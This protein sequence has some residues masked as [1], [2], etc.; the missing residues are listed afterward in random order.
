MKRNLAFSAIFTAGM[1]LIGILISASL[2]TST[3]ISSVEAAPGN[4]TQGTLQILDKQGQPDSECPLKQTD[5]K[6]EIT[7]HLARVNV[8]Q[9]F[10][11]LQTEKI[12]AV[13]VFPL[14]HN[15][16]V[17][18]MSMTVGDRIIKGKIKPRAEDRKSTRLNSSHLGISYAVF[19]LKKK[20]T[21]TNNTITH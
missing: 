16:A 12:E 14:P 17:D 21:T 15:A 10:H 19:C 2:I 18:D 3:N 7:G 6:V 20:I 9:L 4:I 11:N 1:I 8:T 5:V 13:Y